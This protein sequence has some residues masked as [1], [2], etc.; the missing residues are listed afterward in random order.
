M[1]I[2]ITYINQDIDKYVSFKEITQIH[3]F[4][5][6]DRKLYQFNINK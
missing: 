5:L 1:P 6:Q 3:D 2:I 4:N